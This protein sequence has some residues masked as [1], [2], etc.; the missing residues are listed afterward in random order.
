CA[1][2]Q[3]KESFSAPITIETD[4]L[5][6]RR[7]RPSD[8]VAVFDYASDVEVAHFAD[9]PRATRVEAIAA[10][11]K[12]SELAWQAGREF[13]WVATPMDVDQVIGGASLRVM[14]HAADFG[15][16]LS[17]KY[18]GKGLGT[19]LSL[20]IVALALSVPGMRRVSAT[21][22]AENLASARILEKCGLVREGVLRSLTVRPNISREPR[23]AFIYSKVQ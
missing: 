20:A 15:Y 5:R 22:D 23:D 13:F 3:S 10:Y 4:R 2:P 14:G 19:E 1:M 18:W 7:P 16:V 9:W 11:L 21:C 17:R 6:L 8:A 12:E